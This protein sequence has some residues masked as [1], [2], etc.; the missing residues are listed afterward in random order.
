MRILAFA[1]ILL[2]PRSALAITIQTPIIDKI[3]GCLTSAINGSGIEKDGQNVDFNCSDQSAN[4]LYN[5]LEITPTQGSW[6]SEQWQKRVF[7]NSEC[8][9]IITDKDGNGTNA[10]Y[11]TLRLPAGAAINQ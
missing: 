7:G 1:L 10:Y 11:C 5:T 8:Y 4:T 3:A 2:L 9:H 6:G